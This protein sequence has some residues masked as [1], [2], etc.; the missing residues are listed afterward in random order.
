MVLGTI[1]A[2]VGGACT[3][4][5]FYIII[6]YDK[7]FS[8]HSNPADIPDGAGNM[9]Y[10]ICV[11]IVAFLFGWL[12]SSMWVIAG[13]RQ[14][15]RCKQ[16]YYES[17]LSQDAEYFDCSEHSYLNSKFKID[18]NYFET[19]I[20]EKIGMVLQSLGN[21]LATIALCFWQGWF[22]TTIILCSMLLILVS[23]Y[24]YMQGLSAKEHKFQELYSKAGGRAEEAIGS[25]KTVKQFNA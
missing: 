17:L 3:P 5:S 23:A 11:G 4:I 16:A 13:Q 1:G 15:S 19:A 8:R 21:F 24:I 20:G 10:V 18:T 12:M 7:S 2:L 9:V 14:S 22:M 25:I 6:Q